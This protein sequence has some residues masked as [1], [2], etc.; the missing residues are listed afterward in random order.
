[1][2]RFFVQIHKII[3]GLSSLFSSLF[4]YSQSIT[5]VIDYVPAHTHKDA[6]IF[7]TGNINNWN[8]ADS[9]YV[10]RQKSD[11][12]YWLKVKYKTE[13][14]EFKFTR[15]SWDTVE[16]GIN[17]EDVTNRMIIATKADTFHFKILNWNDNYPVIKQVHT[18][19]SNVTVLS[20][21]FFMPQLNRYRRIWLYLPPD[22]SNSKKQYPVLYMHDGQNLFDA[23]TSF[24]GEWQIDETLNNFFALG[25]KG[26]IVVGIDNGG[27]HRISELTSWTHPVYGGGDGNKYAQFISE[28]LK[29]YIDN[30]YRT[31]PDRLNTGVMG[32]SLGGLISFYM[33]VKYAKTFGKIGVFS[34]S[35]WFSD[36]CYL[37]AKHTEKRYETK[38]YFLSGGKEGTENEVVMDTQ[39]MI[40][41]LIAAGYRADEMK[42]V[43]L[44]D[45]EH[46]EWFWR[47][48]F[49]KAYQW[50]FNVQID[51]ELSQNF[52]AFVPVIYH[53]PSCECITVLVNDFPENYKVEIFNYQ[54]V[55]LFENR[56]KGRED[57]EAQQFAKGVYF[58][59]LSTKNQWV[60][61]KLVIT[62]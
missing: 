29:P 47:R 34:P 3:F 61:R 40:D 21:T 44:P 54:G 15:G 57:F 30:H 2:K 28:T 23:N 33:G 14:I 26:I 24:A 52:T 32:S 11:G 12:T 20:D 9:N 37:I 7:L 46:R 1:M 36:S 27:E 55:K 5:F 38:M 18:A 35:F 43:A 16:K 58:A 48:E 50:L 62:K 49:P 53:N 45:G 56:A 6:K 60:M 31:L 22:Y 42:V 51:N 19:S 59:R 17:F 8:P 13:K 41:T 39:R 25:D 4:A 10:F